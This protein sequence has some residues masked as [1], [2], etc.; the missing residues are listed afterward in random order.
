MQEKPKQVDNEKEKPP[1][2]DGLWENDQKHRGYY[3]DDTYG[4][5]KFVEPEDD[6]SEP[7]TEDD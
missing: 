3:Y 2:M 6:S 5:E 4:Y 7:E 1:E